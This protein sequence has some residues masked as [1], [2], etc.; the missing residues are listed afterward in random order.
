MKKL[1]RNK[2][3]CKKCG[4][5]IESRFSHDFKYCSC[6]AI[7][8]DGGLDYARITGEPEDVLDLHEWEDESKDVH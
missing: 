4:D 1:K 8:I 2:I 5:V 7:A 3:Q 6:G